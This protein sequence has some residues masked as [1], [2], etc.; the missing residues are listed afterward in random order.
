MNKLILLI[1]ASII[2]FSCQSKKADYIIFKGNFINGNSK[3]TL[4]K[5]N[6]T[7]DINQKLDSVFCDTIK[8]G[9]GFYFLSK[10]RMSVSLYLEKG[11]VLDVTINS[12]NLKDIKINSGNTK[13][14]NEYLLGER[15]RK[16]EAIKAVGGM[17]NLF[18]MKEDEFISTVDKMQKDS[19]SALDSLHGLSK[20][21]ITLEKRKFNYDRLM[22]LTVYPNYYR[23]LAKD[24]EYEPS[25]KFKSLTS[26]TDYNNNEDYNNLSIYR[27]LV[28]NHYSN[29][30]SKQD[31]NK[32]SII[33][34]IKNSKITDLRNDFGRM[35]IQYL[36]P[37]TKDLKETVNK[38]NDLVTD[39]K[40]KT[41][42]QE[43]IESYKAI[44]K[45]NPSPQFSL[46]DINGKTVT[47][48]S[49]KG[50]AV[51]IDVWATWCGPCKGEIPH[52]QKI[53]KK[54]HGKKI[55]FVSISVDE[56]KNKAFWEKMVKDKK[57]GG[58]QLFSDNGWNIDFVKR[59][60]I[61]GI[62]RFILLDKDGNIVTAQAPR[63]SSNE[64]L[65]KLL[66]ETIK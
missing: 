15:K 55:N 39:E 10:D 43:K 33:E 31:A 58:I 4:Q 59:Y 44:E 61:N 46:K 6:E 27:Q 54:Y 30:Y 66:D 63:P 60:Q 14:E 56:P 28:I 1:F 50:K 24:K 51:Y 34:E 41:Q 29:K 42:L 47:L 23:Y 32:D 13:E 22:Q 52:L 21:F 38:I 12:Q 26:K 64:E 35:L 62:P 25:D 18:S 9:T 20:N 48:E 37:G 8:T 11:D 16:S 5:G 36:N 2:F 7:F 49:L 53:E 3:L 65:I 19:E 17:K 40:I 45:G 57:L